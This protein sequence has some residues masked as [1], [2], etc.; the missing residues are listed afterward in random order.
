MT[1]DPFVTADAKPLWLITLADLALLL[2]GFLVLIQVTSDRRAVTQGLREAFAAS[3]PAPMPVDAIAVAFAPGSAALIDHAASIGWTRD[4]LRDPRVTIAIAGSAGAGEGGVLLASDRA[5][6]VAAALT[7]AG[8]PAD[9]L[10][11]TTTRGPAR[12][13]LTL[14]FAGEPFRS[15]P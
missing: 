5:R 2:I 12:A 1:D 10:T 13:T 9:R 6:A 8:V 11:L 7:S 15:L 3:E 14:A 4:A